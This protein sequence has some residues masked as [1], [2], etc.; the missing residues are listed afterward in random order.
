MPYH[1]RT[2][3]ERDRLDVRDKPYYENLS[4][5]LHLGYRKGKFK[6][7]WVIRWKTETGYRTQTVIGVVPDDGDVT[8]HIPI[9]SFDQ[10]EKRVMQ[11]QEYHCSFCGKSSKEI[12]SLV[13][14]P[15][16]YICNRCHEIAGHYIS[17]PEVKNR[18]KID[19]EGRAVLDGAG[20]PIFKED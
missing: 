9:M 2:S 12:E 5:D 15:G 1:I 4:P 17:N 19:G 7:S 11:D 8:G 18:L 3:K 13:A 10:M 16:V 14:G 6:R 20:K